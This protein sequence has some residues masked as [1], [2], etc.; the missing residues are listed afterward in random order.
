MK[1]IMKMLSA[2]LRLQYLLLSVLAIV[3]SYLVSL[4]PV[5]LGKVMDGVSQSATDVLHL[6]SIFTVLFLTTEA[7]NI[8]RRV[9]VD[10]VSAQ[11]EEDIRNNSIR[12]LLRLPLRKLTANGVSGELTSR[13]YQAVNG[14]SKLMKMLPNDILPV[15]FTSFFVVVQCILQAP[16]IVAAVMLG[17][18]IFT[19][20]ISLLQIQSQHG[21]RE[22]IIKQK[23]K[24]DGNICQSIAGIEQIRSLGAENAESR[25][26]APQTMGIRLTESKHHTIMGLFDV[27]KHAIK[28]IFFVGIIL[29]GTYYIKKG[30]MTGGNIFAIVLLF[31]QLLKPIDELYRFLD[32]ISACTVKIDMLDDIMNQKDDVAFEIMNTDAAFDGTGIVINRYEV[33]SP[34]EGKVLSKCDNVVF[35]TGTSTAL[36]AKTGGGKSSLMKGLVRLYP[37]MGAVKLFG[38]DLSKISQKSLVELV[39]YVPQS[40]FFFSGTIRDNLAYGLP[41]ESSD[42]TLILAL[43]ASCIFDELKRL[44]TGSPTPLDYEIQENGKNLSGGQLKRLAIARAFLRSPKIY[45]F[46]ET[47]ANIDEQT[48]NVIL[49]NFESYAKLI[50]AGIVHISHEQFIVNRC[51]KTVKLEPVR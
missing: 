13:I 17:Y 46:D 25:R 12:K 6:I 37:L 33:L 31:Q 8:F 2:K 20:S 16:L 11:F 23:A 5:Y 29:L 32:E 45:V 39:H 42:D 4:N 7:I 9:F 40:P 30:E 19:L 22:S 51:D 3:S 49:A 28:V 43:E 26:L 34:D 44:S 48:I 35:Q 50:G 18:I 36:V 27:F 15:V 21:I 24:L 10:K 41:V 14:S 47:F 38:V 1:I